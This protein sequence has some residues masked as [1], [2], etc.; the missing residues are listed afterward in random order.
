MCD[1]GEGE[2]LLV[3]SRENVEVHAW[4][5]WWIASQIKHGLQ[6]FVLMMLSAHRIAGAR[7]QRA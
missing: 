4:F 2:G 3:S 1:G 5:A 7:A 6:L